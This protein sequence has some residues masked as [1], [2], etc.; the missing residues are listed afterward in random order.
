MS[1]REKPESPLAR[2]SRGAISTSGHKQVVALAEDVA[3]HSLL[4]R[5]QALSVALIGASTLKDT[6]D[7][8]ERE[9]LRLLTAEGLVV[10][11]MSGDG[12][13]FDNL[14]VAG[15]PP[16][17]GMPA[18][19]PGPIPDAV[20]TNSTIVVESDSAHRARYSGPRQINGEGALVA[21]PLRVGGRA[22]GGVAIGFSDVGYPSEY[23]RQFIEILAELCSA[24]ID[25]ARR[26]D[27]FRE[28]LAAAHREA[29]ERKQIER[30]LRESEAKYRR[31]IETSLEGIVTVDTQDTITYANG[32][33]AQMLGH[34][35][36]E[37]IGQPL[38]EI[39]FDEE[40]DIEREKRQKGRLRA[41]QQ[42]ELRLR[43][44]DGSEFWAVACASYIAQD[45]R[46]SGSFIMFTDINERK[47]AEA[48]LAAAYAVERRIADALQRSLLTMPPP[49]AFPGLEVETL[50][51]PAQ[52]EALVGGDYFDVAM[53]EGGRLAL[54][55]GDV[56]GKGLGA[57]SRTAELKYTLRA[58]LRDYPNPI[59][60]LSRLNAFLMD[61]REFELDA[62]DYFVCLTLVIID[63]QTG[64]GDVVVAGC[65]PPLIVRGLRAEA[66]KAQGVP[67][68]IREDVDFHTC[69]FELDQG[70][71]LIVTTD[72][73]NEARRGRDFFEHE[74][75]VGVATSWWSGAPLKELAQAVLDGAEAWVGGRLTDDACILL[76]RRRQ[77]TSITD[78]WTPE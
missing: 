6:L 71:I 24:A 51:R 56:S 5:Q 16:T 25:R 70:D 58:Y 47:R 30:G 14:R 44:R 63:P 74:G 13:W 72:G 33:L 48:E 76:V 15:G 20:R 10:A 68:G 18:H 23:E 40:P 29:V 32:R 52:D 78:S 69:P 42:Y 61:A 46:P 66:L 36:A 67:L 8:V 28:E 35:Q 62:R 43:C 22:V 65:E 17:P 60:A 34:K 39:F 45:D 38:S 53:I 77:T 64:V 2:P 50:Y 59:D 49:D 75:I 11:W 12:A 37:L 26:Y 4:E 1:H 7:V 9:A 54:V 31:M 73:I 57:A 19:K 41:R 55:V 27:E 21:A 3:E